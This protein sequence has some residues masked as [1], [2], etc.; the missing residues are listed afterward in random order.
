MITIVGITMAAGK[1]NRAGN[2]IIAFFDAEL[3]GL[4]M[5]GCAL[6]RTPRAGMTVTPP[7]MEGPEAARRSVIILDSALRHRLLEAARE[8]Y[9]RLGGLE[10]EWEPGA[11]RAE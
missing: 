10:A 8:A 11:T 4:R 5:N 6:V 2:R 3:A 1:P 9:R 7:K